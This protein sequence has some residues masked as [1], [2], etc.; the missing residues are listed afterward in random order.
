MGSRYELVT[1]IF[2]VDSTAPERRRRMIHSCTTRKL[3]SACQFAP[4]HHPITYAQEDVISVVSPPKVLRSL[5][6]PRGEIRHKS[7]LLWTK[8]TWHFL[9]EVHLLA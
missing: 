5:R 3:Q 4:C 9:Q 8:H 1:V 6:D 2:A 7:Y